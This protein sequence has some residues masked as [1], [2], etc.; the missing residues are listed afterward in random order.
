MTDQE[1]SGNTHASRVEIQTT[2]SIS[3]VWLVP[4]IALIFGGWLAYKAYTERGIFVTI[5]FPNATNIVAGKTK[6]LYKGLEAGIVRSVKAA[7]DFESVD[8]E[9]EMLPVTKQFLTD[10]SLFWLVSADVSLKG[11]SGLETLVSG[12]YINFRPDLKKSGNP[13]LEFV[14]LP[15]S[16]PM[17]ADTP[18]LHLTLTAS[19]LG[20][21]QANSPVTH[22]QLTVG[23]VTSF[24]Y[25]DKDGLVKI[26]VFIEPEHEHL[27]HDNSRFWNASGI[28]LS[29]SLSGVKVATESLASLIAGGIAFDL[30]PY[31][32]PG[33]RSKNGDIYPLFDDYSAAETSLEIELVLDWNAGITEETKIM[34][35]GVELGRIKELKRF[36]T[37][38]RQIFVTAAID[39]RV[40]R[41]LNDTTQFFLVKPDRALSGIPDLNTFILGAYISVRPGEGGEQ[42]TSFKVLSSPPAYDYS[43]P[44]LHLELITP[45]LGSLKQGTGIYFQQM[46]VGTVQN[47]RH[48]AGQ[49]F[50]VSI[51]IRPEYQHLASESSRFWNT[52]GV[53]LKGGL[54]GF[55]I[56][57]HSL[58]SILAGG[59]AF[60]NP[61]T[62][63]DLD[64]DAMNADGKR[65]GESTQTIL[66]ASLNNGH[67]F[68]LHKDR[69]QALQSVSV[70]LNTDSTK[71]LLAGRTRVIFRGSVIGEVHG[72]T[73]EP[74]QERYQVRVGLLPEYRS[75]LRKN[76]VF[77]LV[78]P[79]LSLA[80]LTD[81]EA[82][83]GGAYITLRPGD[84]EETDQYELSRQAP[85]QDPEAQ[86][87]QLTLNAERAGSI[88][89]GSK[90]TYRNV[91]VGQVDSLSLAED[92]L[93][94]KIGVSIDDKYRDLVK[95]HS[96]FYHLSGITVT[97]D[98]S[99]FK[100]RTESA[101]SLLVGGLSFITPPGSSGVKHVPVQDG[102]HY[103]LFD[104]PLQARTAG[105]AI[106]IE[107]A[108][109]SGLQVNS[110]VKYQQQI[111]G[112]V[113]R[114]QFG[115]DKPKVMAHVLLEQG[116]EAFAVVGSRFW[117]A[118]TEIGLVANKHLDSLIGGDYIGVVP[119]NGKPV[120]HFTASDTEPVT[121]TRHTGLNIQLN[122]RR[123]GSIRAG[124]P[125]LY[126]QVKVGEVLGVDLGHSADHVIIFANIFSRYSTL[127]QAGSK[128]WNASGIHLSAGLM[129]GLEL[130]TESIE[131]ILAGGIAFATPDQPPS[132]AGLSVNHSFELH[133]RPKTS[134]LG[135]RP[136]ITI[137]E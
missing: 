26:N 6:I 135:W 101:D 9:V 82:L 53:R 8:V 64:I 7:S 126:R 85:P 115:P 52:S 17:P 37:H 34:Y 57:M 59:I 19:R 67:V 117:L 16:P 122:S 75:M 30:L 13:T 132:A 14:A 54:R 87:L 128:F 22:K 69:D 10:E 15:A 5:D 107:F 134:W 72:I 131:T 1:D 129:S 39:P 119:G 41:F 12:S 46:Q 84:G 60:V 38:A 133:E 47:I 95:Q 23:Y 103:F 120:D 71:Q 121:K 31:E 89:V 109:A 4:F 33:N 136:R 102:D 81:T 73:F 124:N 104:D 96:R 62:K 77:W 70:V 99:G 105:K 65:H 108:D 90:I 94:V 76:T 83:F 51:H 25:D 68:I 88:Q 92:G 45:Q 111:V 42:R 127:V 24:H 18:G 106:T 125:I 91:N 2:R 3:A 27:V 21:I 36:D 11:V 93:L 86:G 130:D 98:V 32:T 118:Q 48:V 113:V 78:K 97:G 20:S 137:P 50:R 100:L 79:Q 123:L 49:G 63:H 58:K 80:G 55:D 29:A 35:Q 114:L 44:G 61:G 116:R 40:K 56:Q 66:P 74:D 28:R 110:K 43:E 112:K